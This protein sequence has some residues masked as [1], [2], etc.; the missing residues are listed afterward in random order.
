MMTKIKVAKQLA[1]YISMIGNVK[2]DPDI[3]KIL[4]DGRK[5]C[6]DQT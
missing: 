4:E 2:M 1:K 3:K 6:D 5:D